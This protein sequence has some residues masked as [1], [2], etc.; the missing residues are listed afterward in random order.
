M[1]NINHSG[2]VSCMA[3]ISWNLKGPESMKSNNYLIV[4]RD[5]SPSTWSGN[6]MLVLKIIFIRSL[7]RSLF[8]QYVGKGEASGNDGNTCSARYH[9]AKK[10]MLYLCI[11]YRCLIHLDRHTLRIFFSFSL[12]QWFATTKRLMLKLTICYHTK[13]LYICKQ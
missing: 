3:A 2:K 4:F 10:A 13:Y 1:L 7:K 8:S 11:F 6:K 12:L 9:L 5:F